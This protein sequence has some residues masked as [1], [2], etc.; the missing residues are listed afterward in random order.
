MDLQK[1]LVCS[2]TGK[3]ADFEGTCDHFKKDLKEEA[4]VIG[5]KMAAVG[6]QNVGDPINFRRNKKLGTIIFCVGL[7]VTLGTHLLAGVTGFSVITYT[8]I[9]YGAL[10]YYKGVKQ[11]NLLEEYNQANGF[12]Q[13]SDN[14]GF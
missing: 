2:L 1:G 6:E 12:E 9:I 13:S 7:T 5:R 3:F 4:Y 10:R 14:V 11:E 8:A